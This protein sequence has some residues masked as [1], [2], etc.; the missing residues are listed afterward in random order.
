MISF[1]GTT[2]SYLKP[3]LSGCDRLCQQSLMASLQNYVE[4]EDEAAIS[5]L[6]DDK[7]SREL[8]VKGLK[9]SPYSLLHHAAALRKDAALRVMMKKLP[10]EVWN[11]R[12]KEDLQHTPPI[13]GGR[14]PIMFAAESNGCDI[15]VALRDAVECYIWDRERGGRYGASGQ[16]ALE[17]LD[18]LKA[19]FTCPFGV[20]S[21]AGIWLQIINAQ[22]DQGD[23]PLLLAVK[24]DRLESVRELLDLGGSAYIRN[25]LGQNAADLI[26]ALPKG[27]PVRECFVKSTASLPSRCT[28]S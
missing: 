18:A 9:Q 27:S 3:I 26:L 5:K 25:R 4:R 1:L 17:E 7:E 28:I 2:A 6:L 21:F 10:L 16:A 12:T 23:T 19:E 20:V 11:L 14:T 15:I 8:I 22:D 24:K 13:V